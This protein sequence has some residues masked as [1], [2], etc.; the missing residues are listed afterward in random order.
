MNLI[1]STFA[2]C[3]L[4][5]KTH[6][7]MPTVMFV[8]RSLLFLAI[9]F[10]L[11]WAIGSALNQENL[12]GVGIQLAQSI[13]LS[14]ILLQFIDDRISSLSATLRVFAIDVISACFQVG[15]ADPFFVVQATDYVQ[16][17]PGK[18]V[19]GV[20]AAVS[21]WFAI[22]LV[23]P[24]PSGAV[25]AYAL[26]RA[27]RDFFKRI[28]P[29]TQ[30]RLW[31]AELVSA[32]EAGH[33]VIVGLLPFHQKD[34]EVVMTGDQRDGLDG[35]CRTNGWKNRS[36]SMVFLELDMMTS[37]AGVEAE[38]ICTGERTISGTSDYDRFIESAEQY[39]ACGEF[40]L[41]YLEPKNEL[42]AAYN[43]AKVLE[44]RLR[45]QQVVRD[46]LLENRE[47]LESLRQKLMDK[48]RVHGK[49]LTDLISQVKPVPGCPVISEFLK[50]AM[51]VDVTEA[52]DRLGEMPVA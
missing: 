26:H 22:K 30:L 45:L 38:K 49:E 14:L 7:C 46:L 5:L 25:Y 2:T 19:M 6:P 18:V 24:K 35:Y 20:F 34:L 9:A 32:H 11:L 13:G 21:A 29:W 40:E 39:L 1:A 28:G 4:F 44:L 43:R 41:F 23:M 33:A 50:E 52:D 42:E 48:G 37:L 36:H 27:S 31:D 51:R 8:G 3:K 17:E 16:A 12:M 47:I 10:N 15:A